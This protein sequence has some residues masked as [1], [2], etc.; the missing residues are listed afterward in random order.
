MTDQDKNATSPEPPDILGMSDEDFSK[1]EAGE[2]EPPPVEDP[3]GEAKDENPNDEPAKSVTDETEEA[4][5]TE[6]TDGAVSED[7][8]SDEVIGGAD[9]T[10]ADP[11]DGE[12]SDETTGPEDDSTPEDDQS[13]GSEADKGKDPD[14]SSEDIDYKA[15]YEQLMAPFKAFKRMITP[16]NVEEVRR[17]MSAGADYQ[18]KMQEMKPY[19]RAFK[20]LERNDLL[21]D[22][23]LNFLIELD[24]GNPDAIKQLLRDKSVD[25]MDVDLEDNVNW[26]PNDHMVS[27]GEI[28]LHE[29]LDNIRG[30]D[31]F[32]RTIDVVTKQWD[33]AS[34]DTLLDKPE[35][36]AWINE[37]MEHGIFDMIMDRVARERIFGKL[38]GLSDLMAYKTVGDAMFEEGAFNA[39]AQETPPAAGDTN[40]GPSQEVDGSGSSVKEDLRNRK[41]AASPTKGKASVRKKKEPNYLGMSDEDFLKQP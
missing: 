33:T 12:S 35:A 11:F 29:V 1:Y 25:P 5:D 4:T 15:G 17:L 40:Q 8:P 28:V 6:E 18:R 7:Q 21:D 27:E 2:W 20:T 31:S 39:P 32:D 19:V 22:K 37:H 34:Q 9:S 41:R 23:K 36:I 30:N 10:P 3:S 13:T 24:K 14:S 16:E 26:Q 38:T